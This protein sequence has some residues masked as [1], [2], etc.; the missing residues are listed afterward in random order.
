MRMTSTVTGETREQ[1]AF[2]SITIMQ[3]LLDINYNY[4]SKLL[5]KGP[6]ENLQPKPLHCP[7]WRI[8]CS[9]S[10]IY[11]HPTLIPPLP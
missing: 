9:F 2:F 6:T 11:L 7:L 1:E 5:M 10:I 4:R 3:R 8:N